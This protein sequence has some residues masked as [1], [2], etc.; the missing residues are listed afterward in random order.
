MDWGGG[1][2]AIES[3]SYLNS[4]VLIGGE[5]VLVCFLGKSNFFSHFVGLRVIMVID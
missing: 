2:S 1:R 5:T 3:I 4:C